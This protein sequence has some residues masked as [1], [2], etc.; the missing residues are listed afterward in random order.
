[1]TRRIGALALFGLALSVA[2]CGDG[3]SELLTEGG[4]RECLADAQIAVKAPGTADAEV[5]GY[6]PLYL[7]TAPDFT[8][9]A[10]DGTGVDVV[11]QGSAERA[12]RTA[13]HVKGTL[14]SLGGSFAAASARVVQGQN[15][16]AVFHRSASAAN[17]NAV[18]ACLAD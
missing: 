8:A 15:A 4:V 14:E 16:V 1:M 6:A 11:V 9:F 10:K 12:R 17:R 7:E 3:G 13:A 18:R 5:P 2:A